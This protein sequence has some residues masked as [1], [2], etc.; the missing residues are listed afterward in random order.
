MKKKA[1]LKTS[2]R[3]ITNSPARFLS[4][5]GIIF[6]GVA[7]FVGIGATGPDMIR[8]ADDYFKKYDL[9]D[10]SVYSSLGF[11]NEDKKI[12]E[13]DEAIG[14]VSLQYLAD[15]HSNQ[16][17]QVF[18][19][20]SYDDKDSLNKLNVVEGRLPS[21]PNE[22]VIDSI[23]Q[24]NEKY[25]IG[26]T[27]TIDQSD[28]V[29]KQLE[30]HSFEIVGFVK[31]PEFIDNA[32]R[33]NT[34]VGNG[35]IDAFVFVLPEA[36]NLD[37]YGR[38]LVSFV[39]LTD[40]V[41]YS[42][43]YQQKMKDNKALLV[44]LLDPRK[45]ERLEEIRTE[46]LDEIERNQ[47][48]LTKAKD[49]LQAGEKELLQA[50]KELESGEKAFLEG[51]KTFQTEIANGQAEIARQE[52]QL[53]A[54][55]DEIDQQTDYLNNQQREL[56][57]NSGKLAAYQEQLEQI[58][59]QLDE[60]QLALGQLDEAEAVFK[61]IEILL[62][63]L[64]QL[65][66]EEQ[67][68]A[69]GELKSL[70]QLLASQL[71]N[72]SELQT[73]IDAII[74]GLTLENLVQVRQEMQQ[75][76]ELL[77]NQRQEIENQLQ[78][79]TQQ[80]SELEAGLQVIEEGQR[81]L[82]EGREALRAAQRQLRE[83]RK[84]L[85]SGRET[86]IVER[87]RGQQKL[88]ATEKELKAGRTTFEK[89][90]AKFEKLQKEK[91]PEL[92][93]AQTRLNEEKAKLD[94][95]KEAKF[96]TVLRESNPGYLEYEQNANRISS[97]ATVFP[98]IFFLIA[99]LVSL[100]TM[101]RMIEEKRMEIG[102]YKALGYKNSE[103]AQKFL[104]YSLAAGLTGT[105]LGL[106]VGFYLFPTIIIN[107]YGQLYSIKEFSTPWYLSYSLIGIAVGLFCTVGI[108]L[109]VL[110]VDLASTA[111]TLLRPKAPKP[112]KVILIE[113]I[114]PLWRR[115][116]FNQKVTMRNL[117]RYKSR[118]F[119]TI[120]GIAGC[121][122]MIVTGF[123]L[124]NSIGDI[125]PIQFN[126]IW[127]YQGI[128]SF[129]QDAT[130]EK[131]RLYQ[132]E[133]SDLTGL[134][135]SLALASENL[136]TEISGENIQDLTVY[137]PENIDDI[138]DFVSFEDRQTQET[139]V[140]NDDGAII[141]EKLSK[142]FDVNVGDTL[143]LKNA[144][145]ETFEITISG[146]VENYVGHFAYLSPKYYEKVFAKEPAFNSELLLFEDSLT[147]N[148]EKKIAN[149]LMKLDR[150]IN[151]SFLSDSSTAL[152]ETTEILNL[153][154]WILI[155]SAGLLAFIV[156][157]NLNN[158][159]IS[160]RIRELSTIKVLGFYNNEVTMY[161]YRE[162]IFLTIFG[163]GIGL[164]F[165][166]ILHGYVLQTVELDMLMFSPK[167]HGLS[168]VYASLITVFFTVVVGFVMYQKLKKVDMIE[169]L[170]SNE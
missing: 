38:M 25:K 103:V 131:L 119:M 96:T 64:E 6:L 85:N 73:V 98:T 113:R 120:F 141:N 170:K 134:K 71:P 45:T 146:V 101:G 16:S 29:D 165:G 128:V 63:Q 34:N 106:L 66:D 32:K 139:F 97:I 104:I 18:R 22:I 49:Q 130:E 11:S 155:I 158:I 46:A 3:E 75:L 1:L 21:E 80:Q 70:L 82:D 117:F 152:D 53:D 78:M 112:G 153:V 74:N 136:T 65:N 89:E 162:N 100:T 48:E 163:V 124:K 10:V 40:E 50:K 159:N 68:A 84:Q 4:I 102:T 150:V 77:A 51:K 137:V 5:L 118:M 7:F 167:I 56:D 111:A 39:N 57:Q 138:A 14:A 129:N 37:A 108:A 41:A 122:A 116:N 17:N 151:V 121:T 35:A 107:A 143:E 154:V 95:L 52:Q 148:E 47:K 88:D 156:L 26:E 168:Y 30:N 161:I 94:D 67:Q 62:D 33:G 99:A 83:G 91:I 76:Q 13:K 42:E 43:A 145:S 24:E 133:R 147:K 142:L 144:D 81:Q 36:F 2:L 132:E 127:H 61:E 90:Q 69:L 20:L 44:D 55:Q 15:I 28:D 27:Y 86:L 160:E 166:K 105:L 115:L 8:S 87:E 135:T 93:K 123:G 12:I 125:V 157:Y 110:R 72:A 31:S 109:I 19:F 164:L 23:L 58:F 79:L 169:A 114:K 60:I 126:Q 92:E 140:L 149:Q 9:A 59:D 54:A